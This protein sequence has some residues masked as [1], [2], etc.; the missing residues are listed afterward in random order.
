ME[1]SHCLIALFESYLLLHLR[2]QI[3]H[4]REQKKQRFLGMNSITEC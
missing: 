1:Y 4:P 3:P 2:V